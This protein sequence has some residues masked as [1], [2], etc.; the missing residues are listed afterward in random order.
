MH[1]PS[2]SPCFITLNLNKLACT[3]IYTTNFFHFLAIGS[4]C[5]EICRVVGKVQISQEYESGVEYCFYNE[6]RLFT[7][8]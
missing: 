6:I 1:I 2:F 3:Q 7:R 4:E 5:L 8:K